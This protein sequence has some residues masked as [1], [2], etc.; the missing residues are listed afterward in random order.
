MSPTGL[1][2]VAVLGVAAVTHLVLWWSSPAAV[3]LAPAPATA[4][5]LV[6]KAL[7]SEVRALDRTVRDRCST[8]NSHLQCCK[9]CPPALLESV[10]PFAGGLLS[11]LVG[12]VVAACLW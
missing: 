10:Q 2:P 8:D 4:D 5:K 7:T 3:P 11:G 1:S 6:L 12:S 9:S